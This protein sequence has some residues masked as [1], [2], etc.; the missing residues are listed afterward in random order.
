MKPFEHTVVRAV[1]ARPEFAFAWLTDYR[2]DDAGWVYG[3]DKATRSIERRDARSLF[4]STVARLA[5]FR[6]AMDLLVRLAP[7]LAWRAHGHV[8]WL[9]VRLLGLD[10][11]WDLEEL[12][13]D[14]AVLTARFRLHPLNVAAQALLFLW[15]A[16]IR[17]ALE[18]TYDRI[19]ATVTT[20]AAA[21]PPETVSPSR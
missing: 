16:Q 1:G 12:S 6:V 8:R 4:V 7:P 18:D 9:G 20:A 3:D 11:H 13:T 19:A 21:A 15:G 14:G 17:K 2:E 5:G 10:A